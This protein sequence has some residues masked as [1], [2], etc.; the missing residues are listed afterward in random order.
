MAANYGKKLIIEIKG[1]SLDIVEE[2]VKVVAELIK[3]QKLS[4]RVEVH[5]FW[6]SAIKF[7]KELSS[8]TPGFVIVKSSLAEE[9][10]L[11]LIANVGANG[12]SVRYDHISEKLTAMMKEKKSFLYAWP[13]DSSEAFERM[14]NMGVNGLITNYPGK[15]KL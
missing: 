4:S 1:E 7:M 8:D 5:S 14:K 9:E 12:A 10:I 15:F 3:R 11:N 13:L 6:P 2:T